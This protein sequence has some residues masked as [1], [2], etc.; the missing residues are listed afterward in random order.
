MIPD[1]VVLTADRIEGV[2][3]RIVQTGRVISMGSVTLK[4]IA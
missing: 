3:K 2:K 1:K 4:K